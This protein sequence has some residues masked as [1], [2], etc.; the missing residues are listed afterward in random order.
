M[1]EMEIEHHRED[2][3][4]CQLHCFLLRIL[5]WVEKKRI[6]GLHHRKPDAIAANR[7]T[8]PNVV[9]KSPR[10]WFHI[11]WDFNIEIR[12][13]G[14]YNFGH[15]SPKMKKIG[16]TSVNQSGIPINW[17]VWKG[18]AYGKI[19]INS[20][21]IDQIPSTL[22]IEV[23][24]SNNACNFHEHNFDFR[25]EFDYIMICIV[26]PHRISIYGSYK[27]LK[28]LQRENIIVRQSMKFFLKKKKHYSC[29]LVHVLH[30]VHQSSVLDEPMV[31]YI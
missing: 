25:A 17:L 14:N 30:K 5:C 2:G 21:T 23:N 22:T 18:K 12:N 19:S 9:G 3:V 15:H 26:Y 31:S 1:H 11:K 6:F 24:P 29:I 28:S 7:H 20:Y 16:K 8:L 4:H 27:I 10:K 13:C